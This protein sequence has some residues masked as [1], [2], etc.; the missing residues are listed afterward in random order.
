MIEALLIAGLGLFALGALADLVVGADR[1]LA[2][3]LPYLAALIGSGIVMAAGV[4]MAIEPIG[5]VSLGATLALGTTSI[6]LD[7]LAGAFL[8]LTS[9][10]GVVIAAAMWSWVRPAGRV[11]G[12]GTAS[13]FLLLLG[14]VVVILIAGDAFTFLFAWESL[15]VSFYVLSSVERSSARDAT[16][17]WVTA[18]IGK[19]GGAALLVGFLLLAG[20]SHSFTI[21]AWAGVPGGALHDAAFTLVLVGF[22]AKVGLIPFQVWLPIGYPAATGPLRAAMAGLAANVGFY[23]CWR[24][25]GVLGHPPEWLAAVVLV[26]G[27]LTALLGIVFAAVQSN[28]DRVIAYSSVENAGIILVGYGVALAGAA[29]GSVPLI[30]LGLLA[31]S[32]QLVT[33]AVAKTGLFTSAAFFEADA[34]S[35]DLEVL[36]GVGRHHRVAGTTFG[37]ASL[38]LAGL[39]PTIGFVSEWFILESLMQEFRLHELALRV[40]MV[41]AGA[42]V[43]L[44]AGVATLTFVRLIGFV[45][46][47]RSSCAAEVRGGGVV[48]RT[49]LGV[50]ATS[51]L[52]LAAIAPLLV[53]AIARGLEPVVPAAVVSGALK[54]PFVLQPVVS[55]FSILSPS[56]VFVVMP[57][58][59]LVVV[60]GAVALSGGRFLTVRRVPSWRSATEGVAGPASYSA[61]GY[62]NVIRHVLGNI[63]GTSRSH[64]SGSS[65]TSAH[66]VVR[67]TVVQPVESYLYRPARRGV[68]LLARAAR[69]L[70]SGR[71]AD[72]LAYM[73]VALVAVVIVVLALH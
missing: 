54:E 20:A 51:C 39:P 10:L 5:A 33:H 15:A 26:A 14:S 50:I 22:G 13:G 23:G 25:L 38:T 4:L 46:L 19:V 70:Q 53:R 49:G 2:R 61:F 35:S 44:T 12:R 59:L 62:A 9:G 58:G 67:S 8:A 73:L 72:Y 3:R 45:V 28:L 63:L 60:A 24:F 52:A 32:L 30:A 21:A 66:L 55:N 43:A 36:R 34:A 16:A 56:W 47:G 71:L 29:T 40:A 64:L 31:A 11:S 7:T 69:R 48:G 41:A 18:A 57:I 1:L 17:S 27:G 42:L 68:L 6:R 37:L 65:P